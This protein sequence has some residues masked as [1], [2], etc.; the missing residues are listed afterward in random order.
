[1]KQLYRI[2]NFFTSSCK[3]WL[4][5]YGTLFFLFWIA[6]QLLKAQLVITAPVT[7]EDLVEKLLGCSSVAANITFASCGTS[8]GF[9]N[10]VNTNLGIDSGVLI[11]SGDV[12]NSIGPNNSQSQTTDNG[13]P[14]YPP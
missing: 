14:G 5:N 8:A 1:M 9:F 12:Y 7:A 13:C 3:G 2:R 6:P 11:S 10:A 4:R